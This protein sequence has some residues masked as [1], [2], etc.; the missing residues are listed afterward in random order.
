[1]A[2][3]EKCKCIY[4]IKTQNSGTGN[5]WM[6]HYIN[7]LALWGGRPTVMDISAASNV[8][9]L[10]FIWINLTSCQQVLKTIKVK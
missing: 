5:F 3:K 9:F 6:K 2:L 7:H 1:M 8:V 4:N 10:K